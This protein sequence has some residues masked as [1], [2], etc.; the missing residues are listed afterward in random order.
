MLILGHTFPRSPPPIYRIL[1]TLATLKKPTVLI[2]S[3]IWKFLLQGLW[4]KNSTFS[5]FSSDTYGL[6]RGDLLEVTFLSPV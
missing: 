6:S 5:R 2:S 1:V 4:G 3:H